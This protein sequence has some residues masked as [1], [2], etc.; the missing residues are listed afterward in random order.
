MNCPACTKANTDGILFCEFCGINLHPS[1]WFAW[2]EGR[3]GTPLCQ[4]VFGLF[5]G[6]N[7]FLDICFGRSHQDRRV[8]LAVEAHRESLAQQN[9]TEQ[10]EEVICIA[11]LPNH[12]LFIARGLFVRRAFIATIVT[13]IAAMFIASCGSRTTAGNV[14]TPLSQI[15]TFT[16]PTTPVTYAQ[17][18]TVSLSATGGGSGN[19]VVFTV[20]SSST[21]MGTISG[22]TLT[23]T[24]VGNLVIDANQAG[25]SSYYAAAQ[26]QRTVVVN[27][28]TPTVPTLPTASAITS[29]Q[30]L[31]SS[32]LSGGVGSVAGTFAWTTPSTVPA[33][34]TDSESVTFTP[35]DTTDYTTV[36][37]SVPVTV[38]PTT[39][40]FTNFT[41]A[42]GQYAV[43]DN[44]SN[45]FLDYAITCPN[46]E[47]GDV[48]SVTT[49]SGTSTATLSSAETTIL[50]IANFNAFD[51]RPSFVN[52]TGQRNNVNGNS[53]LIAFLG[54]ASQSTLAIS[55]TT[56]EQFEINQQSGQI[57]TRTTGGTTGTLF[58][59]CATT[60]CETSSVQSV[61]DDAGGNIAYLWMGDSPTISVFNESGA[62]VC[63]IINLTGMSFVSSIAA[64]GGYMVFTD[65]VDNL[66]GIA[67]MDCSGFF[68]ISVV[69]QPW[70]VAMTDGTEVDAYVFSRDASANGVPRLTKLSIPSGTVEG[71]VDLTG[72]P[73]VTSCRAV[74]PYGC[75]YQVSA[76]NSTQ[77]ANALFVSDSTDGTVLTISTDTSSGK[78]M[79]VTYST[80]IAD[81]PVAIAPQETGSVTKPVLWIG[82]LPANT[83]GNVVDVGAL[84]PA[85]GDYTPSVGACQTGLVGGF[86]AG[87]NGLQCAGGD[88]IGAPLT[89]PY[90]TY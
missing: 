79:S 43:E 57:D 13:I 85:T 33:T 45:T 54:S 3:G 27:K 18:L 46:C 30:T 68:T 58:P 82:Y 1:G 8:V 42:G 84:D 7:I 37:A 19:P 39:P 67:K 14:Q 32:T 20:D 73:T 64:K 55:Q 29:G 76:F 50:G 59:D 81:L 77:I 60:I 5:V 80:P 10:V 11:A 48:I 24:R 72:L 65:P 70:S 71:F 35:T 83:G 21:A 63:N 25:N 89:L 52:A 40:L 12:L 6:L 74:T 9:T 28:A 16:Q 4:A 49:V 62:R 41:I 17:G 87:V 47:S 53:L 36:T 22:S 31:A 75:V 56:G 66:V 38:Y 86:A 2:P 69:G 23:V 26:V 34:G 90:S 61:V 88:T 44:Y 51:Y 78:T 15:I